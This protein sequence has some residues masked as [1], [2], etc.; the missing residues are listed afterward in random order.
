M[1]ALIEADGFAHGANLI[2]AS[3]RATL[4]RAV[5]EGVVVA[6]GGGI[7]ATPDVMQARPAGVVGGRSWAPWHDEP[8]RSHLL[9]LSRDAAIAASL[10][11]AL[12][13][14]SAAR[15]HNW[16]ILNEPESVEVAVPAR[17]HVRHDRTDQATIQRRDLTDEERR[18][19]V[20]SPLRTVLDCAATFPFGEALAIADSALR[21]GDVGE[22]TLREAADL[23]RGRNV[24]GVRAVA[25]AANA[26]AENPFESA[27][28]AILTGVEELNLELQ[29]DPTGQGWVYH[30]LADVGRGIAFEADGYEFHGTKDAFLKGC[31]RTVRSMSR[32]WIVVPC[33]FEMVTGDAD[34]LRD[35]AREIA[36]WRS[37]D[38]MN[39]SGRVDQATP[40]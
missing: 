8:P 12:A 19:G 23:Y 13:L 6:V 31:R 32:G 30:D 7:Y 9:S 38:F 22:F 20:T 10:D 33:T 37:P 25:H 36:G 18:D 14:R 35:C 2:H 39:H 4:R 11:S 40:R 34:W 29:F 28:R 21:A 24:M 3:S 15:R 5:A 1:R 26:L 27:M 16:P 17:R